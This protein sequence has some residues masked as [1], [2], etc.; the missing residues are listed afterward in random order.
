MIIFYV[1]MLVVGFVVAFQVGIN[2]ELSRMLGSNVWAAVVSFMVGFLA[3]LA[4]ALIVRQPFYVK[5]LT[6]IPVYYYLGGLLG[7][8][9]VLSTIMLFPRI[10]AVNIVIFTVLGQMIGTLL[11]DHYGWFGAIQS[12]INWQKVASLLL[13]AI[14][15][16]WFQKSKV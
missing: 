10:G 1:I 2:T 13:M 6:E 8:L 12:S 7:A 15:I 14:A 11:I 4:Y 3:L 9:F 5:K 16:F